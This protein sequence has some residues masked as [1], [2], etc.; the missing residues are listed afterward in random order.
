M[1][2]HSRAQLRPAHHC[3]LHLTH[4]LG[5]LMQFIRLGALPVFGRT[6]RARWVRI[7]WGMAC[8]HLSCRLWIASFGCSCFLQGS[9]KRQS[10]E[11]GSEPASGST[12]DIANHQ[13][14]TSVKGGLQ[15]WIKSFHSLLSLVLFLMCS[16]DGLTLFQLGSLCVRFVWNEQ[17]LWN[18]TVSM[19]GKVLKLQ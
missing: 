5:N 9:H 3:G 18:L 17:L 14:E 1:Q 11:E 2:C 6:G 7:L 16:R 12:C 8:K 15:D 13:L 10:Q 19:V 4:K